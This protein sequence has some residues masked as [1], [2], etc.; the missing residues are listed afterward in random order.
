[1]HPVV[2]DVRI[3]GIRSNTMF[4]SNSR[5][6]ELFDT[7]FG[8]DVIETILYMTG[9]DISLIKNPI[10]GNIKL[11]SLVSL[12]K[13]M[14]DDAF[15][16]TLVRIL[17]RETKRHECSKN[18]VDQKWWK[19]AVF[20]QIYPRSFMDSNGDG[21]GDING[22]TQKLDYLKGL[23]IDAIWLSP[24]YDSPNDDNGYDIRDYEK[25]MEEFGT[26]ADFDRLLF[27]VHRKGMKLIMDL[28]INHTS[29]EHKWFKAAISDKSSPYHDY[30]ILRPGKNGTYPNNW[31]S[32]FG[33]GAWNYYESVN[34]YG[35]HI[36]SKK[37]M[38]LN[39]ESEALRKEL[40]GMVNRWLDK[41]IDGFRLDVINLISKDPQLPM[42]SEAIASLVGAVGY[43]H[44]FYGPRLHEYL[45]ELRAETFAVHNAFSVGEGAGV[46]MEV[47]KQITAEGRKELDE[48]FNFEQLDNPGEGRYDDYEYDLRYLKPLLSKWQ[49]EYGNDCWPALVF[50]NHDNPRMPGKVSNDQIYRDKISKLILTLMLTLRGTPYIYQG[51]EI[52][53]TN[54]RF[55][56]L[57]DLR[58]VESINKYNKLVSLGKTPKEAM[59]TVSKGTRDNARIPMQW[60]DTDHGGF[61]SSD[62]WIA[63]SPDHHICNVLEQIKREDSTYSFTKALI[64][65]RH[66][67]ETLVYGEY[68]P[69]KT[70]N[71]TFCYIR[72]L[73]STSFYIEINLL[74]TNTKRKKDIIKDKYTM[75]LCNYDKHD[76][77]LRPYETTI[78]LIGE[79][80]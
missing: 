3:N 4:T 70:D 1:M 22:I 53:M 66:K 37:Q 55:R 44:T 50:E 10:V 48:I 67:N 36:F 20:Y 31:T 24:V 56:E 75:M 2:P 60:D 51:Q 32:V 6:K 12:S 64:D 77:L 49:L 54:S 30:Y 76:E 45:K 28:V 17:N 7:P 14:L 46:G 65:L 79:E 57:S 42:G 5:I 18:T 33:G 63:C 59:K 29:D 8:Y 47:A 78:Y 34:E 23:G 80:K 68:I 27:E 35:L 58:D 38:D 13:G 73:G 39:W 15:I 74:G 21:I 71:D 26:M 40:Y 61:S 41:G 52:G 11:G 19:S 62:P 16:D 43:E 72:K 25:I 69:V 9:K